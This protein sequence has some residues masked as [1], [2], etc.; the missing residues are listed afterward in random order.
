MFVVLKSN[1][2]DGAAYLPETWQTFPFGIGKWSPIKTKYHR[3][4]E[5]VHLIMS[6]AGREG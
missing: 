1:S 5:Q 4:S 2:G 6:G 3:L